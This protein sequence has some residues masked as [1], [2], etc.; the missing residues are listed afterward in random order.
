[1]VVVLV[2]VRVRVIVEVVAVVHYNY[3]TFTFVLKKRI[4][5]LVGFLLSKFLSS[6]YNMYTVQYS[7]YLDYI[8]LYSQSFVSVGNWQMA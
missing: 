5:P 7:L 1:M 4:L 8:M 2:I 3:F 6:K